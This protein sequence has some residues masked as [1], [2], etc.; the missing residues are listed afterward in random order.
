MT[1]TLP[2]ILCAVVALMLAI[3]Q[4]LFK[5]AALNWKAQAELG[6]GWLGLLSPAFFAAIIL[7]AVATVAWIYALRFVPLSRG[8]IFVLAGAVLVPVLAHLVFKEPLGAQ[9]WVGLAL[10]LSGAYIC[11]L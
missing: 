2:Y 11:S 3:G 6:Q 9:Y 7:Y 4:F 10:V 1:G 8:Y 5:L